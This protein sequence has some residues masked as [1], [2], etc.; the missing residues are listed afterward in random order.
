MPSAYLPG[1]IPSFLFFLQIWSPWN[2]SMAISVRK[3]EWRWQTFTQ[4]HRHRWKCYK[5]ILKLIFLENWK[6]TFDKCPCIMH[7]SF[8]IWHF[9]TCSME[10]FE[11]FEFFHGFGPF[12]NWC[13]ISKMTSAPWR[14]ASVP[15]LPVA[16]MDQKRLRKGVS[17][18]VVV[19][20]HIHLDV[21]TC[22]VREYCWSEYNDVNSW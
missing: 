3:S 6:S 17:D 15:S 4:G 21:P 20:F 10:I 22:E 1:G 12:P 18:G 7:Y 19:R 5:C 16:A 8:Q 11:S 2:R 13:V 14:S 9:H